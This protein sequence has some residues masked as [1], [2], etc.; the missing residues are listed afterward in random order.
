MDP[1]P[2]TWPGRDGVGFGRVD[3]VSMEV[4]GCFGC[5]PVFFFFFLGFFFNEG[6]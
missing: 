3:G 4:F 5:V 2:F 6:E 1:M